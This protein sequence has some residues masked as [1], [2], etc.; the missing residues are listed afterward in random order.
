MYLSLRANFLSDIGGPCVCQLAV[1]LLVWETLTRSVV[2][3]D[4]FFNLT[5]TLILQLHQFFS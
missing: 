2:F 4:I 5:L 1:C 3:I